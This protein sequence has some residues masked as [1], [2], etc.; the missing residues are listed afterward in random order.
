M[1]RVSRVHPRGLSSLAGRKGN[2]K[3]ETSYHQRYGKV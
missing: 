1:N 3:L 2:W